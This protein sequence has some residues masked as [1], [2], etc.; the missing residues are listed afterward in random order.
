MPIITLNVM[1]TIPAQVLSR[2]S[3]PSR[4]SLR[5]GHAGAIPRGSFMQPVPILAPHNA[6]HARRASLSWCCLLQWAGKAPSTG[7]QRCRARTVGLENTL[8]SLGSLPCTC[9]SPFVSYDCLFNLIFFFIYFEE[10]SHQLGKKK[11]K[12][13]P[14]NIQCD[15]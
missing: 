4:R 11:K 1:G 6:L 2:H 10:V 14:K 5:R 13:G 8:S 12:K 3:W 7:A 15:I 9:S